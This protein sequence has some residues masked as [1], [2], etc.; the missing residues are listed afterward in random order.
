MSDSDQLNLR[1]LTFALDGKS[2]FLQAPV[3]AHPFADSDGLA[4]KTFRVGDAL[5]HDALEQLLL[6]NPVERWLEAKDR[7][8]AVG[9]GREETNEWEGKFPPKSVYGAGTKRR[10]RAALGSSRA[11]GFRKLAHARLHAL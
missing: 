7:E 2:P 6:V 10:A 8:A 11:G 3:H 1:L 9:G 4:G 5:L